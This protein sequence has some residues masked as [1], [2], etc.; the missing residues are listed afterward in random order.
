MSHGPIP[1]ALIA[2]AVL[3][4]AA[5]TPSEAQKKPDTAKT[6]PPANVCGGGGGG[7]NPTARPASATVMK[8]TGM[9]APVT[10]RVAG[11][12]LSVDGE[13]IALTN[14]NLAAIFNGALEDPGTCPKVPGQPPRK[15][16]VSGAWAITERDTARLRISPAVP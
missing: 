13:K 15:P 10:S 11:S 12:T 8:G 4:L 1:A 3:L 6:K 9:A 16:L 2:G 5:S 7:G 14:I